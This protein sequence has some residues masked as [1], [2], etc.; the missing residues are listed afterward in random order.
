MPLVMSSAV[1]AV[2][3]SCDD[4]SSMI[5]ERR[6]EDL[7]MGPRLFQLELA[8]KNL[9]NGQG[10]GF[11][12]GDNS[13]L[14]KKKLRALY[15]SI[16]GV[17]TTVIP[18]LVALGTNDASERY[19]KFADSDTIYLSMRDNMEWDDAIAF[20]QARWMQLAVFHSQAEVEGLVNEHFW[21]G[22]RSFVG[23][24]PNP[25]TQKFEAFF[26]GTPWWFPENSVSDQDP[27]DIYMCVEA[28]DD[29][30]VTWD[31]TS[32]PNKAVLCTAN[33]ITDIVGDKPSIFNLGPRP[34]DGRV[35]NTANE[36]ISPALE[37]CALSQTERAAVVAAAALLKTSLP[38]D[39]G[40]Q[41]APNACSY[42]NS[43]IDAFRAAI[44]D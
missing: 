19:A 15:L 11:V 33:S 38:A 28:E 27:D 37:A 39:E 9:N 44:S 4:L 14:D 18:V 21:D 24:L 23:I 26:D 31:P 16:I 6:I 30:S 13:V 32:T 10:L 42:V 1:A 12:V 41:G 5:N 40:D 25:A 22:K 20:C 3:T 2:S 17:W 7:D 34:E 8:L 35:T 36:A 43:S 29:G